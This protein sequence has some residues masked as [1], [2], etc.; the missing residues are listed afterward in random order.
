MFRKVFSV[1]VVICGL[2]ALVQAAKKVEQCE[3]RLPASLKNKL[4]DIRQYKLLEGN[5]MEKHIDCVMKALGFVYPDGTGNYHALIKPLN[6]I[7]NDRK[8]GLNLETCGGNRDK[9]KGKRAYAFYKCM[10]QSSS[11]ESF[12]KVF[13]MTELVKAGK[14]P[15][16]ARF[17]SQVETL[18]KQIDDKICK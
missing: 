11:A 15:S 9:P 14:L 13:D 17:S 1:A 8:H 7:E 2:L 4:C 3:K 10:L 12:K 5:D 6:A 16:T 18:M